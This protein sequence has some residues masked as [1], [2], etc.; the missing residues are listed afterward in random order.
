[1]SD[2]DTEQQ[3]QMGDL[4]SFRLPRDLARR[5]EQA[6]ADELLTV[7]AFVRRAAARAVAERGE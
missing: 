6:A 7:S 1:M 5:I 2:V 4:I 3:M